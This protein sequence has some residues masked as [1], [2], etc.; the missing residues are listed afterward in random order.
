MDTA[1]WANTRPF[2]PAFTTG[3]VI[4]VYDGDTITVAAYI[5]DDRLYRFNIRIAG[6]DTPELTSTNPFEKTRAIYVR[7]KLRALVHN[8]V[9]QVEIICLD[10]YAGRVVARIWTN[11]GVSVA[12][13]MVTEG[14]ARTYEGGTKAPWTHNLLYPNTKGPTA[15]S[16]VHQV[17]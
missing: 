9:V 14:F 15:C 5:H 17:C 7:N 16:T 6:I 1:T 13:Y 3:R 4:K 11:G 12:E 2:I 10:K 8:T